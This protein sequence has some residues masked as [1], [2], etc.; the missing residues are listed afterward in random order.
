MPLE[1]GKKEGGGQLHEGHLSQKGV[2]DPLRLVCFPPPRVSFFGVQNSMTRNSFWRGPE[3][4][5]RVRSLARFPPL[6]I[7]HPPMSFPKEKH[8]KTEGDQVTL[9]L[10]SET[11]VVSQVGHSVGQEAAHY[12]PKGFLKEIRVVGSNTFFSSTSALTNPLLFRANSTCK[13]TSFGRTLLGSNFGV[14]LLE[15][16]FCRHFAAFPAGP[17]R[18]A[19][20]SCDWSDQL[21]GLPGLPGPKCQENL[22][23]V[24]PGLSARS[25]QKKPKK[26]KKSQKSA[27]DRLISTVRILGA[28]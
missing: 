13:D 24:V 5:G 2:L 6:C 12:L 3:I 28:L 17:G 25:A 14:L 18:N 16:T 19:I 1:S 11:R 23:M 20:Q 21:Q 7:L 8:L 26:S 15:Q 9:D 4:V 22:K 10:P 27:K